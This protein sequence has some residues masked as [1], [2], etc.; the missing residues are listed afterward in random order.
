MH[1]NAIEITQLAVLALTTVNRKLDI[2]VRQPNG[3]ECPFYENTTNFLLLAFP[4]ALKSILAKAFRYQ[5][6]ALAQSASDRLKV[7]PVFGFLSHS[8]ELHFLESRTLLALSA[9]VVQRE[10]LK[11]GQG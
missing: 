5:D 11:S 9:V 1:C 3:Q 7:D 6:S 4:L 8:A 2:L 10:Q